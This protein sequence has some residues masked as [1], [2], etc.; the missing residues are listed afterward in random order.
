MIEAKSILLAEDSP[1][2]VEMTLTA[3]TENRLTNKIV[4]VHDGAAALDYLYARGAFAYRTDG[5]PALV[6]LDINLP[7]V[8]GLEVLRCIKQDPELRSIPVVM[9]TSSREENDL[10]RSY[11]LGSNA[12][13]VKPVEFESFIEALRQLSI[14]WTVHNAVPST[15]PSTDKNTP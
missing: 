9:L 13:V 11:G 14:F 12:Y 5:H 10:I 7:K 15:T 1:L 3:F 2:D 4:V 8:D 6:L